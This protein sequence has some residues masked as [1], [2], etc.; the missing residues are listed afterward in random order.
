VP[1]VLGEIDDRHPAAS[2][3]AIESEVWREVGR[4]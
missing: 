1:L 2:E 3:L 4:V